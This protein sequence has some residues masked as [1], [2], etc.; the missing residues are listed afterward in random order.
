MLNWRERRWI[1]LS[2]I[3]VFI[4]VVAVLLVYYIRSNPI[5]VEPVAIKSPVLV[6]PVVRDT[7]FLFEAG[8]MT[9]DRKGACAVT[10]DYADP[11]THVIWSVDIRLGANS[12]KRYRDVA[13]PD[14]NWAKLRY[15]NGIPV[16]L[17]MHM[18]KVLY[19]EK[20]LLP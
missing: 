15:E 4:V 1:V 13:E 18:R 7:T 14:C 2:A 20:I 8:T 10:L 19:V 9:E 3:A 12:I 11:A 5:P 6:P 17:E 16:R